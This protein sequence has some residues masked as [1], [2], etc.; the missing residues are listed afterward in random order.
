[1]AAFRDIHIAPTVAGLF[2]TCHLDTDAPLV[3]W[4]VFDPATGAFL[5]EGDWLAPEPGGPTELLLRLPLAAGRYRVYVSTRDQARGW[6][7]EHGERFLV[8]DAEVDTQ[9]EPRALGWALRTLRTIKLERLPARA[10]R[11]VALPFQI[12]ARHGRLVRTLVRRDLAGRYRGSL[13][14]TG[15]TLL[16]PLLL[17]ATYYFVFAEVLKSRFPGDPSREGFALYFLAGM[18]PWLALS[19]A[20]ARA[21]GV[22]L[23]HRNLIQKLVFPS[24]ILPAQLVASALLNSFFSL[25]IFLLGLVILRHTL[26]AT[27]LWLPV[28]L[29]PQ[30]LLTLGLAWTLAAL[31][32]YLRDLG[33]M[34]GFLLTLWFFLT[35]ICYPDTQLPAASLP[36]LGKNPAY[37]LVRAY[38]AVLVEGHAPEWLALAKLTAL[39]LVAF[40]GGFA[41]FH[42]LKRG[43]ADVL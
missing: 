27:L 5:S 24:E 21:P 39:A 28:I 26:P 34:M 18:I 6:H 40:I 12:L 17:M 41:L 13:F 33:H 1:L 31:G 38:R 4:Q 20:L 11:A 10:L 22:L 8:V 15:W 7:Y 32:A 23:E 2:L 3:G 25:V 43:L 9:G 36:V 16:H 30:V 35:P 14:D 29:V 19:D 42:K 37:I